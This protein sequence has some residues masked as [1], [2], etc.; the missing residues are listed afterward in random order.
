[1]H[2]FKT[3]GVLGLSPVIQSSACRLAPV[4][5]TQ[6]VRP[7]CPSPWVESRSLSRSQ[8]SASSSRSSSTSVSKFAYRIGA[9]FSAKGRHFNAKE[10]LFSFNISNIVPDREITTGRPASGQDAFFISKIG[11]GNNVAFGVA[12]GVGG[13]AESGI[14]SADFSHGLCRYLTASARGADEASEQSLGPQDL[15]QQGFDAVVADKEIRGGGSTACVAIGKDSGH[16]EVAKYDSELR[17]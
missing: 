11:N 10:D 8:S 5:S 13:W 3:I 1:M 7:F 2:P 17:K 4:L 12:D 16:L 14:D 9:S 15:L 6:D